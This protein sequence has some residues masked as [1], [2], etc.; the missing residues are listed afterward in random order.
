LPRLVPEPVLNPIALPPY[1]VADGAVMDALNRFDVPRTMT[2]LRARDEAEFF[3][4][5]DF[6]GLEN[7]AHASRIN[8][9]GFFSKDVLPRFDGG[10]NVHRTKCRRRREDHEI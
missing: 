8:R 10:A 3:L 7:R 9:D 2:A 1:H 6:F 4:G 5:R